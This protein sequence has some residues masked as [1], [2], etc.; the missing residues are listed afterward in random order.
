[1][2]I[3]LLNAD[4]LPPPER[5]LECATLL[6]G[7]ASALLRAGHLVDCG[8]AAQSDHAELSPLTTRGLSL[9]V[10]PQRPARDALDRLLGI[11]RPDL[12][13]EHLAPVA[14]HAA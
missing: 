5:K 11:C 14:P 13:I 2:R 9:H 12:V 10:L 4:P 7:V 8:L 6:R 1:M 3:L